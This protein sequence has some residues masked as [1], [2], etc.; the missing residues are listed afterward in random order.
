MKGF[1]LGLALK[2]RSKATRKWTIL[3]KKKLKVLFSEY[4]WSCSISVHCKKPLITIKHGT[5]RKD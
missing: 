2:Q 4:L 3:E 1:A 5:Q